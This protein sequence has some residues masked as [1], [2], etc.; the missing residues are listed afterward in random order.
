MNYLQEILAF[1]NWKEVNQ[2]PATAIALWHELMAI[3]N[4][5]G[6]QNDFT[7]A[8]GLLQIKSGLSRKE[9]DRARLILIQKGRIDYKKSGNKVNEA[10]RYIIIPFVQNGQREGQ[11]ANPFVQKGQQEG[12]QEGQREGQQT[13]HG[14]GN[15]RD[16]LFKLKR[17]KLNEF[18]LEAAKD[19]LLR[20]VNSLAM[21]KVGIDGL[22]KVYFY[23]GLV[24][25]EVIESALKQAAGKHV[26]YFV[27]IINGL[28]EQGKTTAN[29]MEPI[30]TGGVTF[31]GNA[32]QDDAGNQAGS[33]N[34]GTGSLTSRFTKNE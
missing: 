9:F 16:I 31:G 25:I 6:W 27:E 33:G 21:K 12:Q 20:L 24:D 5:C 4:K 30:Q 8:N 10:G 17:T 3:C 28:I 14:K 32:R 7:V 11:Q 15:E 23:I 18:D 34:L 29:S 13:A 19:R 2:M 22:E 26:N 1:S